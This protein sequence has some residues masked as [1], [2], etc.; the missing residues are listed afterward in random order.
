MADEELFDEDEFEDEEEGDDFE[1]FDEDFEAAGPGEIKVKTVSG[2]DSFCVVWSFFATLGALCIL[3]YVMLYEVY[4]M[5]LGGIFP[6]KEKPPMQ[7]S[8]PV[9]AF[10]RDPSISDTYNYVVLDRGRASGLEPGMVIYIAN[11]AAGSPAN[12]DAD[13]WVKVIVTDECDDSICRA[14]IVG[15]MPQGPYKGDAIKI[16][17]PTEPLPA[18]PAR[19]NDWSKISAIEEA[20]EQLPLLLGADESGASSLKANTAPWDKQEIIK[21]V[22]EKY[23]KHTR[24]SPQK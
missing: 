2:M 11:P 24:V 9:L 4:D 7:S 21:F 13:A 14:D 23:G 18:G 5:R 20:T 12:S 1:E 15:V 17:M 16:A 6:E 3:S 19:F 22:E 8:I 10:G